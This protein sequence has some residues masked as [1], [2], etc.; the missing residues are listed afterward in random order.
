MESWRELWLFHEKAGTW[1]IDVLS[2]G[3]DDPEEGYVEFAGFA[4][5][6]RRLLIA[7]EVKARHR[8]RRQTRAQ[9]RGPASHEIGNVVG[10]RK[11][12]GQSGRLDTVQV[13]ESLDTVDVGTLNHEIC[14]RVTRPVQLGTNSRVSGL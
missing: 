12:R 13:N 11:C 14:C 10:N 7:R 4:P 8:A 5:G 9:W 2:P 3:A 6:P 1:T